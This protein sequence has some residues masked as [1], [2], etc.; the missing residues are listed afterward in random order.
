M[1]SFDLSTLRFSLIMKLY[2]IPMLVGAPVAPS[3]V[4]CLSAGASS[5]WHNAGFYTTDLR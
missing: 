4:Y 1:T 5:V 3:S 2:A